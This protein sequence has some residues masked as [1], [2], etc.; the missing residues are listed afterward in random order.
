MD[1][2]SNEVI[3]VESLLWKNNLTPSEGGGKSITPR[4]DTYLM[5]ETLQ[6]FHQTATVAVGLRHRKKQAGG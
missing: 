1:N 3:D 6:A 4:L 2:Y 5:N